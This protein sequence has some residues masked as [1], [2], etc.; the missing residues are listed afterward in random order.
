MRSYYF[1]TFFIFCVLV[2]GLQ[3]NAQDDSVNFEAVV[4][5]KTLGLNENL[6]VDFKMNKDGDNFSPPNFEGFKVVGGPNQS[7]SNMW[8]NGK[9]TF[10]KS[11][12]YF[13]SPLQKGQLTVG[14]ATIEVDGKLFKTLPVN[15]NVSESVKISRDPNDPSYVVNEN[16]HLVAEI[17]DN[18]PYIN[19]GISIVYKLYYSPQIN[20]T[21]VGEVETPEFKNFW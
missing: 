11:Y 1:K 5:K 2:F 4:S 6:R 16:L 18:S 7:V 20:V 15:I 14:Q 21:N 17:S 10:S 13:L 9:R 3:L 19:E 8:V 12:S